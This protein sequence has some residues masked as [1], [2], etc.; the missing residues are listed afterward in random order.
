[1]TRSPSED[2]WVDPPALH[3]NISLPIDPSDDNMLSV[4]A[5]VGLNESEPAP[6]KGLTFSYSKESLVQ[7]KCEES[8]VATVLCCMSAAAAVV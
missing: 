6:E 7:Q 3:A 2:M 5:V 4:V 1:M 8:P